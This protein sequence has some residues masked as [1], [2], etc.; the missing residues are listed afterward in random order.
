MDLEQLLRQSLDD[1]MQASLVRLSDIPKVDLYMEQ[2]TSFFDSELAPLLDKNQETAF[3]KTMINNYTKAGLLPRPVKKRYGRR[4]MVLLI[5][6]FLLKEVLSIQDIGRCFGLLEGREGEMEPLY[7]AFQEMVDEY[8]SE[9]AQAA[10]ARMDRV[11]DKLEAHGINSEHNRLMTWIALIS[12]EATVHK[13]LCDR[14][15]DDVG[16]PAPGR[17]DKSGT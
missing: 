13:T 8:R 12:L 14:L 5:Y 2:V 11:E 10:V 15:L 16:G 9:Y 3:T 4:H 6:I 1:L 17:P 7:E